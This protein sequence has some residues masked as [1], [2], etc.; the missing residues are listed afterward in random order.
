MC[1][2]R[3]QDAAAPAEGPEE[4]NPRQQAGSQL[5]PWTAAKSPAETAS[6]AQDNR[7]T[8]TLR[9]SGEID[10]WLKAHFR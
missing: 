7:A 6:D 3:I 5:R 1:L 4:Q 2:D 8:G 10:L 9:K